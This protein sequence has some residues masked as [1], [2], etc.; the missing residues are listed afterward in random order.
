ME[1]H[2]DFA[3]EPVPGL[4][5]TLP[6]NEKVV[7]RGAPKWQRL[8]RSAFHV[9]K[10]AAYFVILAAWRVFDRWD[11]GAAA[12][13]TGALSLAPFAAAAIG[14]LTLLAW[15]YSR[16]TIYTLT[17]RRLVIRSGLAL[18]V[19]LNLPLSQIDSASVVKHRDGTGSVMLAIVK[20]SRIAWMVLWP[21]ARPFYLNNPQPTLRAIADVETAAGAVAAALK[22]QA[23]QGTVP[24]AS[25]KPAFGASV[26][27]GAGFAA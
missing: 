24:A 9:D 7:W 5:E 19:T 4:P 6:A 26:P 27:L 13:V 21:N 17:D 12:A 15:A 25:A 23:G 18:P 16:S 11:E 14:I 1:D 20:P 8:A 22:R 10:V 2:D 3:F